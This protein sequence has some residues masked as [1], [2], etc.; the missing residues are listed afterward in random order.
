MADTT[1]PFGDV[2]SSKDTPCGTQLL[3]FCDVTVQI[4]EDMVRLLLPYIMAGLG[5]KVSTD[6][7]AATLMIVTLLASKATLSER[8]LTGDA[9]LCTVHCREHAVRTHF[10]QHVCF[11]SRLLGA[12]L[13]M[14]TLMSYGGFLPHVLYFSLYSL[15]RCT[16]MLLFGPLTALAS[17]HQ[18]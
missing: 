16:A 4:K 6:Y 3:S 18:W 8:L 7:H 5:P 11:V 15:R 2:M 13:M 14:R 17:A 10:L 1:F 12:V 9:C